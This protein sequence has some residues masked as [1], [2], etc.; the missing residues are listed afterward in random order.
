MK[1]T[2]LVVKYDHDLQGGGY[3]ST[4]GEGEFNWAFC[5]HHLCY[6]IGGHACEHCFTEARTR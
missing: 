2:V 6:P 3:Q 1:Y 5:D 4:A